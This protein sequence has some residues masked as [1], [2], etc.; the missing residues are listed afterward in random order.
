MSLNDS[1]IVNKPDMG[2]DK[3]LIGAHVSAEP[4]VSFAPGYAY[5]IGARAFA[6]FT[7]PSDSWR[8]VTLPDEVCEAFKRECERYGFS[9]EAILP[10]AGFMMNPGSPDKRKLAMSRKL[11]TDEFRRC[12]Q[13]GL[14]M[15]NFH[16]GATLGKIDENECMKLIAET[17]NIAL[18]KTKTVKAVIENTAGQGSNLGWSFEQLAYMIERVDDKSR[19]GVCIDTCHA[20]AAGY[21]F[22]TAEGYAKTWAEFDS[23]VGREY[24]SGM[25]LND[26]K[27]EL[28]SRID[29]HERIGEGAVGRAF[30]AR[31]IADPR[32]YGIPLILE[33]PDETLW[34]QEVKTLYGYA[35]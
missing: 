27:R 6:L 22:S 16:P 2:V 24:L 4:D 31:L 21:D 13:L 29:R 14:T 30:F 15:L 11:L 25:H 26:S 1:E 12:E 9:P 8:S 35:V 34:P 5:A 17:I 18:S 20:F 19:V 3:H 33:T 10:H 28:G 32:T 7:A 23:I